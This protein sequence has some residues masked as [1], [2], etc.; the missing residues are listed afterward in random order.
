MAADALVPYATRSPATM[1]HMYWLCRLNYSKYFK[2][3]GFSYLYRFSAPSLKV[4]QMIFVSWNKFSTTRVDP[5]ILNF[6][7]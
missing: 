7:E 3:K 2:Q 4:M 1:L 6:T 5:F